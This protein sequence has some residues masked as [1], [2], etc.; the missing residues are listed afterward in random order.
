MRI[1]PP[2]HN[3]PLDFM[4]FMGA[5]KLADGTPIRTK[6]TGIAA[7]DGVLPWLVLSFAAGPLEF[8]PAVRLQQIHFLVQFFSVI[9][10][11]NIEAYRKRNKWKII[12]L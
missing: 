1:E 4:D 11:W 9:S 2:L 3:V 10:I 8:D 12:A 6:Y 7:I 5:G